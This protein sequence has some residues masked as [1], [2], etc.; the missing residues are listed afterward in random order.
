MSDPSSGAE[1]PA[2][3]ATTVASKEGVQL[4]PLAQAQPAKEQPAQAAAQAE[5]SNNLWKCAGAGGTRPAATPV[6]PRLRACG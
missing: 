4:S 2:E 1:T 3:Q 5:L 6:D